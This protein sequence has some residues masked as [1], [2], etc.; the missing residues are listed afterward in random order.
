MQFLELRIP[1]I[2]QVLILAAAMLALA[3]TFPEMVVPIPSSPILAAGLL[4]TGS[5]IALLGVLEF[6]KARTTTDPRYP[7]QTESMVMCGVYRFSRNPMY[8]GFLLML[9]G[10]ACYLMNALPFLLLPLFVFYMNRFQIQ[11]EERHLQ[12]NFGA[13]FSAYA[14]RVRRWI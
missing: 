7:H 1:P 12:Q 11:P 2:A 6:L 3:T 8:L 14:A 4:G 13:E 9:S 5:I 10:W